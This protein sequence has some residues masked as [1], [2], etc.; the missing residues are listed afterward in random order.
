MWQTLIDQSHINQN[1]DRFK[2]ALSDSLQTDQLIVQKYIIHGTP[3]VFKDDEGKYFDLK[4]EIATNFKENP[5][6]VRMVGSA[7]LG[8]SIAP[9]K[10]WNSFSEESD[11][12]IAIISRTLFEQ[13]WSE[14]YDFDIAL[15]NRTERDEQTYN[16]FLKYFFKG[17]LRPDLFP[18]KYSRKNQ[19]FEYFN[20]ISYKHTPQKIAGAISYSSEIFEKYHMQNIKRIRQGVF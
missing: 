14:L 4:Y 6:C 13:F 12:D 2:V 10:L 20:S 1:I 8:F 11:I 9:R 3:Y 5:E 19:W 7:K 15:A 18:F 16:K 17:W